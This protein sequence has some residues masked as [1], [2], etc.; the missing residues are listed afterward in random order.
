MLWQQ[1]G[2][3]PDRIQRLG[4]ADNFWST[5]GPGP[6]GPSSEVFYDR[7]PAYG[8]EGGPAVDTDRYLELWGLVFMRDIRGEGG[9]DENIP[10]V[11]TLPR[12]CIDTGLG[13]DRVAVVL[14][15]VDNVHETDVTAPTLD[16]LAELAGQ[17]IRQ[18]GLRRSG[19]IVAD[20]V[21]TAAFL[22]SN[23]VLPANEG[24]GFVLR[25]LVRRAVRHA[26]LLGITEPVLADLAVPV[27]DQLGDAWPE[28]AQH[29]GL[30][31][32][33][34]RHEEEAFGRTLRQGARLLEGAIARSREQ[35]SSRPLSGD[36]AF[37]LH[38]T[39]GFPVELTVEIA[40]E[41]GIPVDTDRFTQLMD[42]QRR[43]AQ[44]ARGTSRAGDS[45]TEA[46]QRLRA[47]SGPTAFVGHDCLVAE[48][49]VQGVLAAGGEVAE[50]RVGERAEVVLD[51]TPFY[52]QSGGQVGDTG[53]LRTDD[54]AEVRV[55]DTT[56]GADGLHVHTVELVRGELRTGHRVERK[57]GRR[58]AGGDRAI[59]HRDP[60]P[61]RR[62]ARDA[63]R[64]RAPAR[65]AGGA[66]PAAVRLHALLRSG[67]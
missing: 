8:S 63:R 11:G 13:L 60:R 29:R 28:L 10:I 25:R 41:A 42:A 34:L 20:H 46:Y 35:V 48:A 26:R 23:G 22:L 32:Q 5:G 45:G 17:D 51:R 66:G 52:A 36:T 21:R 4:A 62:A 31:D 18:S 16:L 9:D 15:E 43:R 2:I 57:R 12:P 19:R 59:A 53:V 33:A 54:G 39:F 56:T 50:I 7:G 6:C 58:T 67:T 37:E 65:F 38:D 49:L 24:S 47:R 27:V 55:L 64:P 30:I 14:Q 40:A 1:V 61:A 44:Q 3:P